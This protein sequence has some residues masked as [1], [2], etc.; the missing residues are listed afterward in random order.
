MQANC[1]LQ[2]ELGPALRDYLGIA[3]WE[4]SVPTIV[5]RV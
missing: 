5:A 4:P 1:S 2:S 3:A